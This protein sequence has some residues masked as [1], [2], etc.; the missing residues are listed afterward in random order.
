MEAVKLFSRS[1]RIFQ[2]FFSNIHNS[3]ENE[4]ECRGLGL[5]LCK[6][7]INLH[8]GEINFV[9]KE[10][11]GSKFWFYLPTSKYSLK[12]NIQKKREF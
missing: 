11:C 7:I 9:S 8:N 3:V 6:K 2:Y 10:N 5:S 1:H 4:V 12:K